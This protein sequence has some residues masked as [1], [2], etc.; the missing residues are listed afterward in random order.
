M[1]GIC[2]ILSH[3]TAAASPKAAEAMALAIA[4]RGPDSAGTW[5]SSG[6]A[7]G[8]RRLAIIDLSP[9][10]HQPMASASGRFTVSFNGEIYNFRELRTQLEAQGISFR[11]G[12]DT[13]VLLAAVER[14]GVVETLPLLNGMFALAIWDEQEGVAYLARDRFGEKPLYYA[15]QNGTFLFGSELKALRAHGLLSRSVDRASLALLLERDCIPAP[16]TI[17]PVVRKLPPATWL[18]VRP[19]E[20]PSEPTRFWSAEAVAAAARQASR[21]MD[22]DALAER[23]ERA[24]RV[25]V[26]L[27]MESD[28]PLGAFL[29]GGI[30]SSLIVSIMQSESAAAVR[31]FTIGWDDSD[32]DESQAA[33]AVAEHLGTQHTEFRVTPE[34]AL[35]VLPALPRI[36][37]EPFAD[38]SQ[39]PTYLVARLARR[40]VTVALSGDGG[41][42]LFGGYN[43][44]VHG[45]TLWEAA[46]RLPRPLR[47]VGAAGLLS[48]RPGTWDALARLLPERRRPRFTGEKI[49]KLALALR[50]RD[51]D[52]F[53]ATFARRWPE[54]WTAVVGLSE[55]P[56]TDALLPQEQELALAE[57]M[58]LRDTLTYLP[59]DILVKVDRASMAHA[60]E[61]RV[62]FL[63]PGVFEVAWSLPLEARVKGGQ[64]KRI[65]RRLLHRHVPAHLVDRPK[66][67][68]GIPIGEWLRGP[69]RDW[70]SALLD[71]GRLAREGYLRPEP[72][73]RLWR[74]HLSGKRDWQYHLWNVLMFQL[75]LEHQERA[76]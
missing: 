69:L 2:G 59:D 67:G 52:E 34:D 7:L 15:V 11:G 51:A 24:L 31:T 60:L 30:D 37:D 4:H 63:D 9:A 66:T 58:M 14:F 3:D 40:H 70:A 44:H 53:Y 65:L 43:R 16:R 12:S 61:V 56:E 32:Y 46:A 27:R 33:R 25:A 42:E 68:F 50:S 48:M 57:R 35:A 1:C 62:P 19:G 36:Y 22:E 41:D 21:A 74:E 17:H 73:A 38:A 64:G 8:H 13:E 71:E 20:A 5:A 47:Q 10:G 75:W 76:K 49:Q 45:P 26:R 18:S 72:V 6:V 28:V 23:L 54:A 39:I 29:S 55:R